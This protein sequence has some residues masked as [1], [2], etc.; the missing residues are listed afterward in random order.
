MARDSL[1]GE[2]IIWRGR[3]RELRA[4]GPLRFAAAVAFV[5]SAIATCFAVCVA[6]VLAASPTA[7]LLFAAWSATLG[8]ALL[9]APKIWLER[10]EYTI[11]ES[12]VMCRRGPFRRMITRGSISYARIFW[13]P[14]QAGV[15]D[16]ELVRAVPTGALRRRLRLKLYGLAAPDKVWDIIR[17]SESRVEPNWGNRP[18]AQ[19]LDAGER[20]VWA[21]CPHP[22]WKTYLPR[23]KQRWQ[24]LVLSLILFG[25][26][27]RVLMRAV[28]NFV[29][30]IHAG[31]SDK[32]V[33]LLA[34]A[35]GQSLGVSMLLGAAGYLFRDAVIQPISQ[36]RETRYMIT[37][38][39]VLI[40]RSGEELHL[41]REQIV[42][43]ID[44]PGTTGPRDVFLILDGPQARAL[45]VSGA[46]GE[47]GNDT[48]L[49]PVLRAV[50]DA[51]SVSQA[52][53]LARPSPRSDDAL[54]PPA[55]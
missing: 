39:R 16:I 53:G 10:M 5:L 47:A 14:H 42:D 54:L 36:L 50:Y 11:T 45:A 8:V 48:Q 27:G 29:E 2:R 21:A 51:D 30:L 13:S 52:L 33:A 6:L 26:L 37:N 17:G 46:F 34:L 28:P 18:L 49:R 22:T 40:E 43:V 19:R 44:E 32:P 41:G 7:L 12:H 15:G 23:V 31:L 35:V 1:L 38:Q 9:Q 20:V 3:P 24:T 4:P 25:V 55:A